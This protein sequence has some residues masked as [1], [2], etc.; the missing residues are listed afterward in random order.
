MEELP[1][2][3]EKYDGYYNFTEQQMRAYAYAAVLADRADSDARA[4]SINMD[5]D[6]GDEAMRLARKVG[7]LDSSNAFIGATDLEYRLVRLLA[8]A[9]AESSRW[10]AL[11]EAENA[12]KT[13]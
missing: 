1:P 5:E 3:P 7:I 8:E 12:S 13:R 11:M 4:E 6:Y 2:L 9:R 10:P